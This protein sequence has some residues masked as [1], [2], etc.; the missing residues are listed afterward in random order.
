MTCICSGW[1]VSIWFAI[2]LM[3]WICSTCSCWA[4]S[5]KFCSCCGGWASSVRLAACPVAIFGA[6]SAV[7]IL[8]PWLWLGMKFMLCTA[9]A[10]SSWISCPPEVA[11]WYCCSW[12]IFLTSSELVLV[13]GAVLASW[14]CF[15]LLWIFKWDFRLSRRANCKLHSGLE[16]GFLPVCRIQCLLLALESEKD[17]PHIPQEYGFSPLQ[18]NV[19]DIMKIFALKCCFMQLNTE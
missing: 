17:L 5:N 1:A 16:T 2:T 3:F 10:T 18:K 19:F 12:R 4:E 9:S 6:L 7:T 15:S 14:N 13:L 8:M 11:S